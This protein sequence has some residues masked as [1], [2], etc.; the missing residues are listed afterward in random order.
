MQDAEDYI[1]GDTSEYRDDDELEEKA[2]QIAEN[3]NIDLDN[4]KSEE[5]FTKKNKVKKENKA[6]FFKERKRFISKKKNYK[7]M[8]NKKKKCCFI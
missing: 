6:E 3:T 8:I 1:E 7:V 2:L 5:K 4:T